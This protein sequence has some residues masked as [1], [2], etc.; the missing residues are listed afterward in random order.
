MSEVLTVDEWGPAMREAAEKF[1]AGPKYRLTDDNRYRVF[2]NYL[3]IMDCGER[4]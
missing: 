2:I 1:D 4:V 3:H